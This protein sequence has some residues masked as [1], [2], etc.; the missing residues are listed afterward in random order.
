MIVERFDT[1]DYL[2]PDE[3]S[4]DETSVFSTEDEWIVAH[5]VPRKRTLLALMDF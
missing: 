2:I 3:D 1:E 4:Q 5:D